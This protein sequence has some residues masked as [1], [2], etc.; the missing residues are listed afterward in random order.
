MTLARKKLLLALLGLMLLGYF[1]DRLWSL[2]T[3]PLAD[4][5]RQK[6]VLE[7]DIV[8]RQTELRKARQAAEGLGEYAKESLPADPQV[9]R[10]LYQAWLLQV[11]GQVGLSSPSVDLTQPSAR[12]GY[13]ALTASL[14]ARGTLLQWTQWF[15]E[16]YR[17][18]QLHQIRSVT[19]TPI[20]KH[21]QLDILLSIEALVLPDTENTE[22]LS[23]RVSDR[24]AFTRFQD[25]QPILLRNLFGAG[26]AADPSDYAF[27]TGI[28]YV[29][30]EPE[31]WFTLR[32]QVDP[33]R[34]VVK[35]RIGESLTVGDFAGKVAEI[36]N[37]DVV[38]ES[39]GERWLL[40]LGENL[41]QAVALPPDL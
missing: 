39:D 18:G 3:E 12:G 6:E 37:D 40:G 25:Y 10:S 19:F 24:L 20:T 23:D 28:Q 38:L 41:G 31:V 30:G 33:D 29:N 5:R 7:R 11:V 14:K 26:R 21:D 32:N 36:E 17:S 35:L 34:A 2:V 22:Q 4:L 1:G 16:F 13:Y 27:L 9:A 15:Y 8:K